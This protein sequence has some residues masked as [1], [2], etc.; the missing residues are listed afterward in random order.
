MGT[1]ESSVSV[2]TVLDKASTVL[3]VATMGTFLVSFLAIRS[4]EHTVILLTAVTLCGTSLL[5]GGV[6]TLRELGAMVGD[7]FTSTY[8]STVHIRSRSSAVLF[9][10]LYTGVGVILFF[11]GA[12][13]ARS[14]L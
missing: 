4:S 6:A 1:N 5:C 7:T 14:T 12:L 9:A 2:T 10:A 3:A 11:T 8:G 13:G